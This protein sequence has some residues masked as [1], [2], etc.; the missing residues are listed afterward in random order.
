MVAAAIGA[1]AVIG[2]VAS[3]SAANKSASATGGAS[4]AAIAEQKW[5]LGEQNKLSQ[6]YRD[7]GVGAIPELRALLGI[8]DP[9]TGQVADRTQTLRNTPGYQF[10]KQEGLDATKNAASAM[11]LSMSGNTLE[12]L[13]KFGTGL[14]D[15]TYQNA[16]G[17]LENTVNTGQVA[18]AG[19]AVNTGNAATNISGTMV[20]QGNTLAGIEANRVA[21]MTGAIGNGVNQYTQMQT[22]NALRGGGGASAPGGYSFDNPTPNLSF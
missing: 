22:L 17:N 4:S 3:N 13:D 5:A 8:P 15:S 2:G 9:K 7:L 11:G 18:A 20:N 12:A 6:P 21:G 19:Q 16:V 14:A 1:S 10:Q